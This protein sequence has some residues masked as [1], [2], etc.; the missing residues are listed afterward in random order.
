MILTARALALVAFLTSL[1]LSAIVTASSLEGEDDFI[2]VFMFEI[3]RRQDSGPSETD[4][5]GIQPEDENDAEIAAD[6][7]GPLRKGILSSDK[8]ER[9]GNVSAI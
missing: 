5:S 2:D 4:L 7:T 9:R 6:D 3:H 8:I 1:L